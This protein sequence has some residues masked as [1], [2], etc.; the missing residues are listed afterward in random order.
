MHYFSKR[1][2]TIVELAIVVLI[3]GVLTALAIPAY[4]RHV[5]GYKLYS[6]AR[7]M[8]GEIREVQQRAI[9]EEKAS[10]YILF[11]VDPGRVNEKDYYIVK[12]NME[13]V[14]TVKLDSA[15][16]LYGT[17]FKYGYDHRLGFSIS[18]RP[19]NRGGRVMLEDKYGNVYYV[20]VAV[21]TGRVR[22]DKVEPPNSETGLP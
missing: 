20:I 6:A 10:Y 7:Q 22:I 1:G 19:L 17:N 16:N 3:L 4:H 2:F 5:S 13:N 11:S 21:N 15:V 18:G 14:K 12:D 9:A 8:V